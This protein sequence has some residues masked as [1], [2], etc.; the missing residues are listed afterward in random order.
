MNALNN[1]LYTT[2]NTIVDLFL[3]NLLWVMTML[4]LITFFPATVAMFGVVRKRIL[5]KETEGI[6]KSF[7]KIF[8]ENFK[9]SFILSIFWSVL[10]LFLFLDYRLIQPGDSVVQLLLY[11][12]LIIGI[13]LFSSISIYLFPIMVHFE[14]S[15]K[16]VIRNAFLFSL[17]NPVLTILLLIIVG[18]GTAIFYFYP[19]T[20]FIIGSLAAYAVYYL[21]Q[22]WFNQLLNMKGTN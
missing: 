19:A 22:L 18:A 6:V 10:A 12:V 7:F 15:W 3:L 8:K 11:I 9:Q 17:M 14:L 16:H 5:Q 1:R 2:L 4:P 20:I 13:L 21:C